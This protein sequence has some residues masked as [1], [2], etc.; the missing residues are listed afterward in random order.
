MKK[1][2]IGFLVLVVL[3]IATIITVPIIFK[4]DIKNEVDKAI[5]ENVNKERGFQPPQYPIMTY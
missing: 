2:L 3:L 4:D 5:A 1:V